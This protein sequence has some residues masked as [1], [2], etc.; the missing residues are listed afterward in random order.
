MQDIPLSPRDRA[1]SLVEQ[2]GK[3]LAEFADRPTIIG[4]GLNDF[5]FDKHFLDGFTAAFPN[6]EVHA[7]DDAGHYLLEDKHAQFVPK[8]VKFLQ[9]HPLS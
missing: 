5:V 3:R 7:W 9:E 2:S 4:W 6:A 1:W 8:V